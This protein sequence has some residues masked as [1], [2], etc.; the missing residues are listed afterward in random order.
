[1]RQRYHHFWASGPG[2]AD[3]H[4]WRDLTHDA[5]KLYRAF[6]DTIV[7]A[8][9]KRVVTDNNQTITFTSEGREAD[10]WAAFK[11]TSTPQTFT[12]C[13]TNW[14]PY[15]L[16]VTAILLAAKRRLGS[17]IKLTSDGLWADWEPARSACI[18]VL[19]Y[20]PADFEAAHQDFVELLDPEDRP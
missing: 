20:K 4:A 8:T 2:Q 12:H 16:V 7:P 10:E 5:G 11:L 6:P 19:G 1:M 3:V 17:W 9:L 14:E 13:T 18:D 15:D